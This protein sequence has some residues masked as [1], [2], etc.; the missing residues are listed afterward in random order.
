MEEVALLTPRA[1][2]F[3]ICHALIR[4]LSF[5]VDVC[6]FLAACPEVVELLALVPLGAAGFGEEV[7]NPRCLGSVRI[8]EL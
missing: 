7:A 8:R 4:R 6:Q 5:S 2:A 3:K 1:I